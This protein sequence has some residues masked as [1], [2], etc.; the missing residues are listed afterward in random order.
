MGTNAS[1]LSVTTINPTNTSTIQVVVATATA[2][3]NGQHS[4][5]ISMILPEKLV[6]SMKDSFAAAAQTCN[7]VVVKRSKWKSYLS[8]RE[9]ADNGG[10][11]PALN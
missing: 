10:T 3:G 2:D 6:E 4:G 7:A 8:R 1:Y 9:V 11:F 5:D